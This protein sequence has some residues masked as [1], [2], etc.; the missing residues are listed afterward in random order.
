MRYLIYLILMCGWFGCQAHAM[1]K[2]PVQTVQE[3][4][5][6]K[7]NPAPPEVVSSEIPKLAWHG[8][9]ADAKSWTEFLLS[10][11]ALTGKDL[12]ASSPDD[13]TLFCPKYKTLTAQQKIE[14]YAQLISKMTQ[15]ESGFKPESLMYECN[16][17]KN[18]YGSA[19]YD[20][21]RG[22]CMKGGHA[23]DGG[24]VISRGLIQM[25]LQSAQGYKCPLTDPSELHDPKKNLN[26]AIRVL[27]RFVPSPR[28]YEGAV[29]GHN[30][31]AGKVNGSWKGGAAYWAVLRD[32]SGYA[33]ESYTAIRNYTSSL[34]YCK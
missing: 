4:A 8:K 15:Y 28:Q 7:Q 12:V 5:P 32:S 21:A 19:R 22:W 30:R 14:F 33:K 1:Q 16:K 9:H 17:K 20:S 3:S 6:A 26:C 11:L 23:K 25:S 27:N 13:A 2:K 34:P 31:I 24:Y 29:R 10:D 18:P